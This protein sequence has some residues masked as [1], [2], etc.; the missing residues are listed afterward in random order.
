MR[1]KFPALAGQTIPLLITSRVMS[2]THMPP[3]VFQA[4]TCRTCEPV[5]GG[6]AVVL[7]DC[8]ATAGASA[9]L[10]KEFVMLFV[11]MPRHEVDCA[12]SGKLLATFWSVDSRIV[13]SDA[14][15]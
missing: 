8:P 12:C 4:F 10:S 14:L 6:V 7:I 15:F 13:M 1:P 2:C 9:R 5:P 11:V 3:E